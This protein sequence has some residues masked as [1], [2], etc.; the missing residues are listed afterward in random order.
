[1][2]NFTFTCPKLAFAL[3]ARIIA[4]LVFCGLAIFVCKD[5]LIFA[6]PSVLSIV[7]MAIIACISLYRFSFAVF[8]SLILVKFDDEGIKNSYCKIKY[9]EIAH[10]G[11]ENIE[12][13]A[14]RGHKKLGIILIINGKD[15]DFKSYDIKNSICIP[16]NKKTKKALI[17][18][19]PLVADKFN[20]SL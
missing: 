3:I 13:V 16:L 18:N 17:E 12:F 15:K 5:F 10:I 11:Y 8:R 14:T 7:G 1:M 9:K 6:L 20:I 2:K 4:G 19:A